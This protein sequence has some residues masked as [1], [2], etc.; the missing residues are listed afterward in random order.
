LSDTRDQHHRNKR[1]AYLL[2]LILLTASIALIL[3]WP[4]LRLPLLYDDLLHIRITKGLDFASVW[5]P[6]EDFGFYR[7]LTFLPLLLI[8]GAFGFYPSELLHGINVLQ[9]ALNAALLVAL[10]WRLW[11]RKHWAL[12]AGLL[13]ALF[14]FSYQ[15]V[16]VYGHN[17]HPTTTGLILGG[18]HTYLSAIRATGRAAGWWVATIF[19]FIV[20][21]LSHESGILFGALVALVHWND[22][23][24]PP[25]IELHQPASS[26]KRLASRPWFL[27]T[28]AGFIYAFGYQFLNL[29]R[30][31]QASFGAG[32]LWYKILYLGQGAAYPVTRFGRWL[33]DADPAAAILVLAGLGL[34]LALT[35][36]SARDKNNRLPLLLGWGWWALASLL[37]ALPLET[38]YLLHGPRLLYLSSAGLAL[39][40][41]VLIEP[42]YKIGSVGRV[43]WGA[44]LVV[45]LV[46]N[47]IYIRER[48][49]DYTQLT[50]VVD[51]VEDVMGDSASGEG[52][53]LV[54]LPQWIDRLDNNY[55]V[56]VDL[57][58]MLG[59][60]LFVEEL[61]GEN[62]R[63]DLPVRTVLVPDLLAT[64]PEYSYGVHEQPTGDLLIGDWAPEGSHVF[65]TAY[66]SE[67]VQARYVGKIAPADKPADPVATFGPYDL[68]RA[69]AQSCDGIVETTA[70]WRISQDPDRDQL[71]SPTTSVFVQL[72]DK[73]GQIIDQSDGPFLSLRPELLN[74][75]PAWQIVDRRELTDGQNEAGELLLGVY[76]YGSG[77]RYEAEE[78]G[79][80]KMSDNALRIPIDGC[81]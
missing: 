2:A 18:L 25:K 41:P 64:Y 1:S 76:D 35:I 62:L 31:P 70:T 47:W 49:A 57:V 78:R 17:V 74:L 20:G 39:L 32:S 24:R 67:G 36:W 3:Y 12:A 79:G 45:I 75:S 48:L 72:I 23:G 51:R 53:L 59:D 13:F 40:W 5:L 27:F 21:L 66:T 73:N 43:L 42:L 50:A 52:V 9:H 7:P 60:Y 55:P 81:P 46:S 34:M 22:R 71:I 14:P 56:G 63:A 15:A 26:L 37:V 44:I 80:A 58:A 8:K 77:I 30:A 29:S 10:S 11:R 33:P 65:I 38:S 6:T 4:T 69:S 68:I 19:F 54:N 61:I 16:A 28:V